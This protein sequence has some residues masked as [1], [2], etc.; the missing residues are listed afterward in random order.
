LE[1]L[2]KLNQPEYSIQLIPN[3]IQ[4]QSDLDQLKGR[5]QV[6]MIELVREK[7]G[8]LASLLSPLG[9]SAFFK[10]KA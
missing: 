1:E 5:L 8:Q 10:E 4:Q 7:S 6:S 2:A 9:M 3:E